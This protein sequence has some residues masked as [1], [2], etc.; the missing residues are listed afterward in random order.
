MKGMNSLIPFAVVI[1][2]LVA[3]VGFAATMPGSTTGN[4]VQVAV[5]AGSFGTLVTAVQEAGLVDALSGEGPLTVFAPTDDAFAKLPAGTVESLLD[6]KPALTNVLTYHVVPGK[7][8][9]SDVASMSSITTLQGQDLK[10]S[11]MDGEVY[12]N[13][14]KVVSADVAADNG[15]IHVIDSVL[16]PA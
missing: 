9:A 4:I 7:L 3:I 10:V 13:N 11:M 1:L 15:V 6:D 12:I 8:M 16:I 2:A 5:G 14:A